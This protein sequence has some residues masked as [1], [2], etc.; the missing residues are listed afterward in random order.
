MTG[1]STPK[2]LYVPGLSDYRTSA[3]S[4]YKQCCA[5]RESGL[6]ANGRPL[7]NWPVTLF[8]RKLTRF[9]APP[10]MYVLPAR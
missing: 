7:G 2:S 1:D 9:A 4:C 5:K 3:A 8:A 10:R 6:W